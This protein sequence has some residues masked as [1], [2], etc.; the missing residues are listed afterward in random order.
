MQNYFIGAEG[1]QGSL[2]A[3]KRRRIPF[4]CK[5]KIV[6]EN[7]TVEVTIQN[8]SLSGLRF[9][10]AA[11]FDLGKRITLMV[12]GEEK[13]AP[14]QEKVSG[15]ITAVNRGAGE[16]SYGLEFEATLT[17]DRQ[18]HLSASLSGVDGRR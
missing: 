18:P 12:L 14:F 2:D 8:L 10:C 13:G 11:P 6:S 3:R 1:D 4:F 9:Q 7:R 16:P 5:G 15:R 17:P